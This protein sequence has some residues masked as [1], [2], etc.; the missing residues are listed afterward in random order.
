MRFLRPSDHSRR[1][2]CAISFLALQA[3]PA[4]NGLGENS[5]VLKL[6]SSNSGKLL[7]RPRLTLE[8]RVSCQMFVYARSRTVRREFTDDTQ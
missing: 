6:E 5:K 2:Q 8:T 4:R 3:V 1:I 7:R